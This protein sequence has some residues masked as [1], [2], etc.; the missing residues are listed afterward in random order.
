MIWI[1][2]CSTA[3]CS[4]NETPVRIAYALNPVMCGECFCYTDAVQ[5][6]EL[7]PVTETE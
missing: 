2:T 7:A 1:F 6:D 4:Q 3:G 5:T